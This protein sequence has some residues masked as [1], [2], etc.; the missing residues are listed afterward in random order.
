MTP[1]D[2]LQALGRAADAATP[3]LKV[4]D[5]SKRFALHPERLLPWRFDKRAR[6]WRRQRIHAVNGVDLEIQ[7]GDALCVVGESGC[8]KSTLA[9]LIMGLLTPSGGEVHYDG[10]RVDRLKAS[11]WRPYRRRLQMIFQ[12]P[13]ASLNPRLTVRQALEEPIRL[14]HAD[15][16]RARVRDRADALMADVGIDLGWGERFAH[17][18]SGGQRQ[19][20]AIAR[21]LSV[22]PEFVI[23]D[24]PVSALDLSVQ[25]QILNLLMD[26]QAER[27][28]TYLFITHDL[29]VVEHFATRVAVMYLGTICEL[30]DADSLFTRPRHPYTRALL[31]ASPRL[32][33]GHAPPLRLNGDAS[34]PVEPP[35]GCVFRARCPHANS[36]CQ[37]ERPL[38]RAL[39]DGQRVACHAVEEGRI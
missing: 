29:A 5:L 35:D 36:R 32:Q 10:Q 15:W 34:M 13:Y 25:A 21:A 30:A 11:Q 2:S 27:R 38:P 8:G 20:I 4:Q 24:E 28:L 3:L 12:N 7:R 1:A 23:A 19:R 26:A 18:F 33:D 6:A 39:P 14:H 9:R 16:P 37:R 22:D 31:A 17:E